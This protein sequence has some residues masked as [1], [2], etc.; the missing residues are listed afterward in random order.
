MSAD[1]SSSPICFDRAAAAWSSSGVPQPLCLRIAYS[2]ITASLWSGNERSCQPVEHVHVEP[3]GRPPPVRER[4]HQAVLLDQAGDLGLPPGGAL[5]RA[6]RQPAAPPPARVGGG[7]GAHGRASRTMLNGVS[8]ARRT[9]PKPPAAITSRRRASPA[10]APSASPTS[11]ESEEG[12][13]RKVEKPYI[14]RPIGLRLSST[15]SPAAGSTTIQVPSSASE[16]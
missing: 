10:W 4:R 16:R 8:A 11:C 15:R 13:Q 9:R 7:E 6:R 1:I 5:E 12:V 2:C 3:A 14:A